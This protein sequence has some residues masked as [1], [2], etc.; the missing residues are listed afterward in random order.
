MVLP[1]FALFGPP[2]TGGGKLAKT[3]WKQLE[4]VNSDPLSPN[5]TFPKPP[6]PPKNWY[7]AWNLAYLTPG[8]FGVSLL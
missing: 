4:L 3:H 5:F 1:T 8:T 2:V 6:G 7:P